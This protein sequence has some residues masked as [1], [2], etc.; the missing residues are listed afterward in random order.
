MYDSDKVIGDGSPRTCKA[1]PCV[2]AGKAERDGGRARSA[3]SIHLEWGQIAKHK[4]WCAE[5]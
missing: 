2:R 3:T 1:D 4:I 5:R